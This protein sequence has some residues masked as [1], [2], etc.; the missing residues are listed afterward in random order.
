[1]KENRVFM[2]GSIL[3]KGGV[4][5]ENSGRLTQQAPGSGFA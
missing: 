1:M 5:V 2:D 3:Q 4:A